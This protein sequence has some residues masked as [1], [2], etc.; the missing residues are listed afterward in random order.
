MEKT[1]VFVYAKDG[2]IKAL[3]TEEAKRLQ[4]E[5][6]KAGWVH[7]QTLNACVY[8]QYLHNDCKEID[9]IEEI[10]SLTKHPF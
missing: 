4:D 2:K 9:L 5:L 1:Y 6:V 3:N 7:T 10:K 8:I